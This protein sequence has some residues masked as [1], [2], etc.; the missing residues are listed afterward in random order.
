MLRDSR[1]TTII[2][3]LNFSFISAFGMFISLA[4]EQDSLA[5]FIYSIVK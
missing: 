1:A 3:I 2:Q 4:A 5:L